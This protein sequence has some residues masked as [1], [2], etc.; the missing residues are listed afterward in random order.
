MFNFVKG[1][2]LVGNGYATTIDVAQAF[3]DRALVTTVWKW[4]ADKMAWAFYAPSLTAEQLQ[5]YAQGKG[6][7]VLSTI[8]AGEGFWVNA[9][10]AWSA[11]PQT[12]GLQPVESSQFGATGTKALPKGWSLIATGDKPTPAGFNQS[13]SLTPPSPGVIPDNVISLWAWEAEQASWQFY[14]PSLQRNNTLDSYIQ[15]KGY[16]SFGSRTLAPSSGFWV[17]KP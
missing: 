1:W 12:A 15:G 17:N 13:L 9:A 11:S 4:L 10:K 6:Y 7:E 14:A 2:N 3:G 8:G 16:L 5:S